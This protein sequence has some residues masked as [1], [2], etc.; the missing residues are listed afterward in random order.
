MQTFLFVRDPRDRE[1]YTISIRLQ[2]DYVLSHFARRNISRGFTGNNDVRDLRFSTAT[3]QVRP[4]ITFERV[5]K[6]RPSTDAWSS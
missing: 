1:R 3:A 5:V 6:R 4:K 2:L